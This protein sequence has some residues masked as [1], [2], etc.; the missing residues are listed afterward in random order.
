[1]CLLD[2]QT[3]QACNPAVIE[4]QLKRDAKKLKKPPKKHWK[5]NDESKK[6]QLKINY[7]N[8][9]MLPRQQNYLLL[10]DETKL[11]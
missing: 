6:I 11:Y 9:F 4:W 1:M 10:W 7:T 8:S 2:D 3:Y 5:L